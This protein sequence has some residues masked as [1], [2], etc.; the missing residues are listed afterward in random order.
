MFAAIVKAQRWFENSCAGAGYTL[1]LFLRAVA[2][3]TSLGRKR[4]ELIDQLAL[5][6]LGS[7]PV[8]FI[9]AC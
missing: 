6:T 3:V 2:Q 5:C 9:N 4:R 1:D 7:L 8:V